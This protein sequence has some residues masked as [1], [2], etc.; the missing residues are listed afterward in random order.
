M[1]II[2]LNAKIYIDPSLAL[3]LEYG[4]PN[5]NDR[6]NRYDMGLETGSFWTLVELVNWQR[7]FSDQ[8]ALTQKRMRHN[9]SKCKSSE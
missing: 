9:R 2:I 3:K 6:F 4:F 5:S 7:K 8:R 1:K